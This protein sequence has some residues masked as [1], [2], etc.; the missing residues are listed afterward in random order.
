[1]LVLLGLSVNMFAQEA[2]KPSLKFYGFI[3]N[4]FYVDTYKGID[5]AHEQYYLL[6]IYVGKDANGN[7]INQQTSA[8][9]TA[10]ASR[11]GINITGPEIFG[12][13]SSANIETDF[14]G[15]VG[16]EPTLL[17]IRKAYTA[18]TWEK[19]SLLMGQTWHPFWSGD[20]FPSVGSLNTGAP[21]QPFN[22]AP[23]LRY[24][25]KAGN[26]KL[27]AAAV[28][29][30]QYSSSALNSSHQSTPTQAKRNAV[31]PE[32]VGN[33]EFRKDALVF[34]AGV[35]N[36][37]TK[38]K[39]T[40][41]N[42]AGNTYK[43]DELLSSMA[44][45]G[46]VQYKKDKLMLQVKSFYGQNLKHLL[47]AGGYGIA[48]RDTIT[49]VE[50]YTNYNNLTAYANVVYGKKWQVGILAGYGVN[51]GTQEALADMGDGTPTIT[52]LFT[53]Y[54]KGIVQSMYRVAPHVALNVSKLRMVLEY[55]QTTA[56]YG[57]GT[58]DFK[59]GLFNDT[60]KVTNNR[61]LFMMMYFF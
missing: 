28:Y 32:L 52:G 43:A 31:V 56:N 58:F 39:M 21:F 18:L 53:D 23:Q 7:D 60:Y 15:I 24:D 4:E 3:R 5:G 29:Q 41:T 46:Y 50:T 33:I 55:E 30:L 61:L 57:A 40:V 19:S 11:M 9:M 13:K 37:I 59:N 44:Y 27:T 38:P 10:I 26:I 48:S 51:M 20:I 1:M 49:G 36:N 45:I 47:M 22:R 12:A 42:N 17:R 2:A 8:N 16:T 25:Y 35:S 54:K 14:G 34:G 6:P